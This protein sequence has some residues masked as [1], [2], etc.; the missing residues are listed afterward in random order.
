MKIEI[1]TTFIKTKK[2]TIDEFAILALIEA[3]DSTE[4]N[5]ISD[6]LPTA[7][8]TIQELVKKKLVEEKSSNRYKL[9][10]EGLALFQMDELFEEFIKE[11]PTSVTRPNGE[12]DY[13]KIDQTRC[14][15]LYR[16]IIKNDVKKHLLILNSMRAEVFFRTREG[17]MKYFKRLPKWLAEESWMAYQDRI[18]LAESLKH[19]QVNSTGYGTSIE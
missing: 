2:I 10:D 19:I 3:D 18:N 8:N 17:S 1:D 14:K 13:L 12:Y 7:K 9:T 11:F 4:I 16:K 6:I 15:K 5:H